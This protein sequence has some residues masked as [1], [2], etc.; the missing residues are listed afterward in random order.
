MGVDVEVATVI[1]RPQEEVAAFVVDPHNA[2]RWYA[3]IDSVRRHD[4]GPVRVG[5]KMEFVARFLGRELV[6]TYEV[7]LYDPEDRL[8]MRTAEGPFPMETVYDWSRVGL[9]TRVRLRNRGEPS[10]FGR[11]AGPVV[12]RAMKRAMTRDLAR[13][14]ALLESPD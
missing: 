3:N 6:Y 10:G 4:D 14:K 8:V 5:T 11:L 12:A 7:V 13:L 2:P 9:G 1:G